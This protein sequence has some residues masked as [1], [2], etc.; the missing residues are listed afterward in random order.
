MEQQISSQTI[1]SQPMS[2]AVRQVKVPEGRYA[3]NADE[4]SPFRKDCIYYQRLTNYTDK[5]VVL[6][7]RMN[8]D[9][10]LNQAIDKTIRIHRTIS[11]LSNPS[12][13][14]VLLSN[15]LVIQLYTEKNSMDYVKM[16]L[17]G[18]KNL[19]QS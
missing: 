12:Q 10:D 16:K 18:S 9:T 14:L 7:M 6:Q 3:M 1:K 19:S 17:R 8:M 13:L 5:Q 11:Q 2:L 4:F 15:Q